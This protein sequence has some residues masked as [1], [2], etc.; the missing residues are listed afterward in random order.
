MVIGFRLNYN[1]PL[2]LFNSKGYNEVVLTVAIQAGGQ[3]SRLGRDK[4]L[5]SLAGIPLIEHILGRVKGLGDEILITSNHPRDY[6]FP[7]VRTISDPVPGAGALTA[8]HTALSAA[9]GERVLVLACDMPFVS[10]PLLEHMINLTPQTDVIVPHH[11]GN[12][13]PLHAVYNK[14]NC[15]PAVED[16]LEAGESRVIS[17]FPS[18]QVTIVDETTLT[19][20]DPQGLS[21]FNINT[22]EDLDQASRILAERNGEI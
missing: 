8:L 14:R 5:L 20:F 18:V 10:R 4:G 15:L 2:V 11:R 16:A 7:G 1:I 6:S 21:F 19:R 13:E 22:P 3:S 17:F 9:Q 12:Y